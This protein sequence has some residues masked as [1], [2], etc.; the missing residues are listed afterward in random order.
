MSEQQQSLV[1][2]T[3]DGP[4]ARLTLNREPR[5]NA[6]V[7]ELHEQLQEEVRVLDADPAVRAIVL[8]GAGRAFC[9]GG[10]V[11]AMADRPHRAALNGAERE[12]ARRAERN[13]IGHAH[14]TVR[15]LVTARTSSVA[16]VNGPAAG[17][18]LGLALACDLRVVADTAT[19]SIGFPRI[20]LPGDGGISTLLPAVIGPQRAR[21]ALLRG[22]RWSALEALD[23]GLV[24]EVASE[25]LVLRRATEVAEEVAAGPSVALG[26]LRS[27]L[28]VPGNLDRALDRELEATLESQE[29][30][31][32]HEGVAAFLEGREPRFNGR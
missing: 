15:L 20:G 25:D 5:L 13:R 22:V 31:D 7:P 32:H 14:E 18:G 17:A 28:L 27:R 1:L 11:R 3:V 16:A 19:L 10:D 29:S 21:A 23:A 4:V 8:T 12:T 30:A 26:L 24:D 2:R 6:L 9:A